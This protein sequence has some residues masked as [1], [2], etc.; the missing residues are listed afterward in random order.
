[1][2]EAPA[3]RVPRALRGLALR[4]QRLTIRGR[5]VLAGLVLVLPVAIALGWF[6]DT[7]L[8]QLRA[9]LHARVGMVAE[10]AAGNI[11]HEMAEASL[12]IARAAPAVGTGSAWSKPCDAAG[13]LATERAEALGNPD[14]A[15]QAGLLPSDGVGLARMERTVGREALIRQAVEGAHRNH[16]HAGICGQAPSDYPEVVRHLVELGIDS[17][18][19]TP[20]TL[21]QTLREVLAVERVLGRPPRRA[22]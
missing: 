16:R 22:L 9:A 14:T 4:L 5:I 18:S 13:R 3:F 15:F 2:P 10:M 8:V 19:V 21:L 11:R 12:A 7:S 20:D 17:I 6:L 1:M